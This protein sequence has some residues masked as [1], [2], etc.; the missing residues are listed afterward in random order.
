MGEH[1]GQA[2]TILWMALV[3]LAMFKSSLFKP[4]LGWF[5]LATS[6][7]YVLAQTE[8]LAT[9]IPNFFVVSIAGLLGSILWLVWMIIMGVF[10]LRAK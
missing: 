7:I 8:L 3:S 10:L 6:V 4:W 2:F 5:G 9:V 1:L